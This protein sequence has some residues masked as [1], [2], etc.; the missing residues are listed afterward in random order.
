M[1]KTEITA[2]RKA[3]HKN[4]VSCEV[5]SFTFFRYH[6]I[7]KVTNLFQTQEKNMK[8]ITILLTFCIIFSICTSACGRNTPSMETV[9]QLVADAIISDNENSYLEGECCG[10]GHRILGTSIRGSQLKVYALTTFGYYGFQNDMFVKVSGSGVIPAVLTF[11]NNGGEYVF[12]GI[13]YPM[14]GAYYAES[15]KSMFPLRYRMQAMRS[16]S[17]QYDELS[18]Q[19]RLYAE[20]YLKSIGREAEIGEFRDLNVVLLTDL[21]VSVEVS[22]KLGRDMR[23]CQYPFWIGTDECLENGMRYVRALS[24]DEAAGQIVFYTVEKDTGVVTECFVFDAVSGEQLSAGGV[25]SQMEPAGL[26]ADAD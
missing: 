16:D 10:E 24:Y 4:S 2:Q 9:S 3:V 12:A 8:K 23:L 1:R 25:V 19:E 17:A 14:D 26:P 11:E 5:E 21:G 22:N 6:I 13:E 15:I 18:A 20:A 7:R